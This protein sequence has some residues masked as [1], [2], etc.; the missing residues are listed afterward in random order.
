VSLNFGNITYCDGEEGKVRL[1]DEFG[2]TLG[3]G[4]KLCPRRGTSGSTI[5]SETSTE[6]NATNTDKKTQNPP[7][8]EV[9]KNTESSKT[10]ETTSAP[11]KIVH[12]F[13]VDISPR[14]QNNADDIKALQEFFNAH[15]GEKLPIT[16]IYDKQ[17]IDA[18]KRFQLKYA[19]E[20]LAPWKLKSPT[21]NVGIYTRKKIAAIM[22][23]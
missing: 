4:G 10:E 19:T 3:D 18:V 8:E 2:W 6:T 17:T 7:A 23:A 21:G 12:A 11:T 20:I 14:R 15:E 16:G 5:T 22:G 13:T 9:N 1:E